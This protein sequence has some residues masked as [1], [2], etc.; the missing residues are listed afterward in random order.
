MHR[1]T[2]VLSVALFIGCVSFAVGVGSADHPPRPGTDDSDLD[3]NETATLWS[4]APNECL[5]DEVYYD[6]YGENR[7]EMHALANCTDITFQEP[8]ETAELWTEYDFDSLEPGDGDTSIYP[9]HAD[10]E[11]SLAIEDA[12]ATIFAAQ[13][14]TMV[15]Q[16]ENETPLYVAP[17]G[18]LRGLVD[19]RARA[20]D[21]EQIGNDTI[22]WSV[23]DHEV[24]EIQL[25]QDGEVIASDEDEQTPVFDYD[26]EGA[27]SSTLRL[28]AD[29]EVDLEQKITEEVDNQTQTR[30]EYPTDEVTVSSELDVEVYDL[31]ASIYYAEYPD[32][33]AGVAIYQSQPWHGYT[34]TEDGE[35]A[36]RGV[37]RYYTARDT[38]WDYLVHSNRTDEKVIH[39]DALP[40]SVRA[41]PSEVGPRTDP[42]IDGP[43]IQEIW[44]SESP[45][46]NSTVHENVEIDVIDEPY[47]QS[48]GMA[49][50]YTDVDRDHLEVQGIV[51]GVNAELVEP[52]GGTERE[53]RE[54][55]LSVEIVDQTETEATVRIE[56]RDNETGAPIVLENPF[57][58]DPRF[59]PIGV[60]SRDGYI[61]IGDEQVRTNASGVATVTIGTPGIYSAEYHPGSWRTHDP[62]YVGDT[63]SAAWHPLGSVSGWF[64]LLVDV[65][66]ISIPFLVALYAGLKLGSFFRISEDPYP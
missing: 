4:K 40:V 53:I 50:R 46:P 65:F 31:T 11:S 42:I 61:S 51:R 22:E 62:A 2:V 10:L 3:E 57:E 32:G 19:Y 1:L 36:V 39:S 17:E 12:H 59:A 28:E 15:H 41:Y 64:A 23:L 54:S 14:S 37:W 16:D 27:G 33:D 29:I 6:R 30:Y 34:L 45:S 7:T 60:E 38:D 52:E 8:P 58:D 66:W 9:Q 48:H 24:S 56:L 18:E 21:D 63:S 49:I 47:S 55:N 26:L 5:S 35:A 13:P 20:P 43:E 44:G 25:L